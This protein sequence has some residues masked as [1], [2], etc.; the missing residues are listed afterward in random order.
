M[1]KPKP[2]E[3][4]KAIIIG[5]GIA[6]LSASIRLAKAGYAV[7]IFE[8]SSVAGG[9]LGEKQLGS[10]RFDTGP[11]LFTMPHYVE[12]LFDLCGVP[13]Q[14]YF[15]YEKVNESCR[16]FWDDG[17]EIS[18]DADRV[19]FAAACEKEFG[20]PSTHI[21]KYLDQSQ[22]SFELTRSVF[23]EQSLHRVKN[24]FR[25]SVLRGV[26][27]LPQLHLFSSMHR[28]NEKKIKEPHLVQLFDR[29]AT[30]NGSDPYR[31]PGV[32]TMIPHL[33]HNVGTFFP[34]GGMISIPRALVQLAIRCG[35]KF[36]LDTEVDRIRVEKGIA[37]GVESGATFFPADVVISNMDVI[38]TYRRLLAQEPAPEKTLAQE[39]SS[40][41]L[42]FYWG[43]GREFPQLGLHNIFFANDYRREFELLFQEKSVSEDP[44]VYVHI[45]SKYNPHDA[46]AGKEA[47]FVL[48]NVPGNK[49][50]NWDELIPVIRKNCLKKL[51]ARLGVDIASLI[52]EEDVLD[53]RSIESRTSS[54]QGSLYGAASNNRNAA[55]LRH[56]NFSRRIPNLYFCGGSVHPGG[57]IPLCLL[58]GKITADLIH[59]DHLQ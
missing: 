58:S 53:P 13:M 18:A 30:Y 32:L 5:S 11:S 20:V 49:G 22:Q 55:F 46:P 44:T 12:E 52:E 51:S 34:K 29:F 38:P 26:L 4:K 8:R 7:E 57:G 31:A 48:V 35:V 54:F 23:L 15:S 41:A 42:I 37:R 27:H 9:K 36:H 47:W 59:Q 24:Y 33:E 40:S 19:S 6:G 16:Y 45:S 10:Y 25:K 1:L 2:V 3:L 43:I 56:P 14:D 28:V 17:K 21:L 39:R 50:Q